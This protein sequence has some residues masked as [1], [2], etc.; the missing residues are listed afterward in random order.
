MPM[1]KLTLSAQSLNKLSNTLPTMISLQAY[2]FTTLKV[3]KGK[4]LL[5]FKAKTNFVTNYQHQKLFQDCIKQHGIVL[6][7]FLEISQNSCMPFSFHASQVL[8]VL[9]ES[10]CPMN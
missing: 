8:Q 4:H 1:C 10:S 3:S 6:Q 9:M 2:I 7:W 5:I